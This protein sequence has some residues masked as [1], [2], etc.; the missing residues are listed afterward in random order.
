MTNEG[1]AMGFQELYIKYFPGPGGVRKKAPASPPPKEEGVDKTLLQMRG[2]N[3]RMEALAH[4][5]FKRIEAIE[6]DG[7]EGEIENLHAIFQRMK[8]D[9]ENLSLSGTAPTNEF[10]INVRFLFGR[11]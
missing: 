11:A 8:G 5:V 3:K 9:I 7:M 2:L 6:Q 1:L 4:D 10:T